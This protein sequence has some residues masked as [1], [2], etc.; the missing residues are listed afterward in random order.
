MAVSE[1]DSIRRGLLYY[2]VRYLSD[3]EEIEMVISLFWFTNFSTQHSSHSLVSKYL[4]FQKPDDLNYI[5]NASTLTDSQES[6]SMI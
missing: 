3:F 6:L 2:R 4:N 1:R 5:T